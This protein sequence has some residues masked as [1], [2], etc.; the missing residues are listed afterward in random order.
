MREF[1]GAFGTMHVSTASRGELGPCHGA[2]AQCGDWAACSGARGGLARGGGSG[3]GFAESSALLCG[4]QV[5]EAVAGHRGLQNK[6]ALAETIFRVT[7]E[8]FFGGGGGG[9]AGA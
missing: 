3:C 6:Y 5:L 9:E 1:V 7:D 2:D 4:V 8:F